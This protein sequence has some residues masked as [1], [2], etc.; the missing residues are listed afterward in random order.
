[1]PEGPVVSEAAVVTMA[2]H[3]TRLL[4]AD[5]GIS[6]SG[7]AGPAS[8]DDEPPGTVWMAVHLGGRTYARLEHFA[9]DP[10]EVVDATM[11]TV[12][13]WLLD[14]LTDGS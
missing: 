14:L 8:Q 10:A 1:V 4:G 2:E 13:E 9:G 12:T 5:V 11:A 6:V 7:V 3:V